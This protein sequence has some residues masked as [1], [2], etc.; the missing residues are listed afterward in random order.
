MVPLDRRSDRRI[1]VD[2]W[3]ASA[4]LNG[5]YQRSWRDPQSREELARRWRAFASFREGL[6]LDLEDEFAAR[7]ARA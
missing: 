3:L 6:I 2:A 7:E 4:P 5:A 1:L